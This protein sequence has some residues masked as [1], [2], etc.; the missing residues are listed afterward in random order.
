MLR[1]WKTRLLPFLISVIFG[2]MAITQPARAFA[3][4]AV[5]AAPQI[6]SSGASVALTTLL[7]MVGF[8]GMYLEIEDATSGEKVRVPVSDKPGDQ[9][10]QPTAPPT[11]A[12]SGVYS[13]VYLGYTATGASE[14][15]ACG[16]AKALY[17]LSEAEL[18]TISGA[19]Q[20]AAMPAGGQCRYRQVL[21]SDGTDLGTV[22]AGPVTL[23]STACGS[24]YTNVS[25]VCTLSNARQA[26]ADGKRDVG[27]SGGAYAPLP[28]VDYPPNEGG[29]VNGEKIQPLFRNNGKIVHVP[30]KDSQGRPVLVEVERNADNTLTYVRHYVQDDYGGQTV[31]TET[32]ATIDTSTSTVTNIS[33]KTTPGSLSSPGTAT[34]PQTTTAAPDPTTSPTPT[35]T[36]TQVQPEK[37]QEITVNTCGMPGQP[38]CQ[39][40]DSAFAGS[41]P[42]ITVSD[43]DLNAQKNAI[44]A[45]KDL[46]PG[47]TANL[48]PAL[49]PGT[50]AS[51]TPLQFRG[52]ANAG[53]LALDSTAELDICWAFEIIRA[54]AGYLAW[55]VGVIYV[56]RRFT[57]SNTGGV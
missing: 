51:C 57:G 15:E 37:P 55:L 6:V 46:E 17:P 2:V 54:V 30:G 49:L 10:P 56:W 35:T 33:A 12:A 26:Q 23:I 21:C 52:A 7:G 53:G 44:D 29:T 20:V 13:A 3:P 18:C 28:D 32:E 14:S 40:D 38:K 25:G 5:I 4:V 50:A 36:G 27:S 22:D 34:V 11:G 41:V 43:A 48:V 42:T 16:N 31:V 45:V 1:I 19:K 9:P 8:I 47:F 24:G 39:I